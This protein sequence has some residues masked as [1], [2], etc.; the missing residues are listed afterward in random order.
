MKERQGEK[1]GLFTFHPSPFA[2]EDGIALIM[3]LFVLMMLMIVAFNYL[4]ST[5]ANAAGTRNLKEETLSYYMALS[6]YQEALQYLMSDKDP[7]FDFFDTEGNFRVDRT[8]PPVTGRRVIGD[9]ELNIGITD[10]DSKININYVQPDRFKKLLEYTGIPE[11]E[12]PALVD[13][14]QDWRD[15]SS[16]VTH[17]LLGAGDDYYESLPEPYTSKKSFFD[18]PEELLL[19]KGMKPEYLYGSKEIHPLLPLITTFGKGGMNINT[20]SKGMMTMLG[21]NDFEIEAVMK[22]RTADAGGFTFVPEQF[23]NLG[24]SATASKVLRIEVTARAHK[25]GTAMKVVAVV[26]R[27]P[28]GGTYKIHTLYWSESAENSRS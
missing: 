23:T 9:G 22:Q 11:D 4:G 19:V 6:G 2:R 10:E 3:V 7:S 28:A 12:I 20:V 26:E 13:S 18:V 14:V 5:R 21:M 15:P 1:R 8:T 27:Q 17:R 24:F 25:E 16:K